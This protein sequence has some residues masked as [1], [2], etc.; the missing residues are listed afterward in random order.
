L[1]R[2]GFLYEQS[3][4]S[5]P[6]TA[7]AINDAN[8]RQTEIERDPGD[9]Q[10]MAMEDN[11]DSDGRTELAVPIV[12]RGQTIGVLGLEDPH[13]ARHWTDEDRAITEAVSRQLAL[14]LE[15]SRLLEETQRRA[16][17]EQLIGGI[18]SRVRETLDMD[19]MLKTA[20]REIGDALGLAQVEVRMRS[21]KDQPGNGHPP[22]GRD[23]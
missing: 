7:Q 2:E 21:E 15:N 23:S 18:T 6:V 1:R 12:L 4:T 5:E 11:G 16:A 20:I 13:G 19:T 9:S 8:P 3:S 22:V 14:A 10:P 17:R